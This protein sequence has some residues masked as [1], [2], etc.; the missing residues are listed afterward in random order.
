[1][2]GKKVCRFHGGA[3]RGPYE[4]NWLC[5]PSALEQK[6]KRL[7]DQ[8]QTRGSGSLAANATMNAGEFTVADVDALMTKRGG[9]L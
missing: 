6:T 8:W 4:I 1:L 2:P 5:R 7:R 9:V 3:S